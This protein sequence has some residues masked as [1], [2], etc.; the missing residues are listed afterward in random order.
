MK[1]DCQMRKHKSIWFH[2]EKRNERKKIR[3]EGG[4]LI[5][6]LNK[7]RLNTIHNG[8]LISNCILLV[9][10]FFTAFITAI[11]FLFCALGIHKCN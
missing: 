5:F 2:L 1:L 3:K 9:Y 7:S 4:I 10:N 8:N 6:F 11:K